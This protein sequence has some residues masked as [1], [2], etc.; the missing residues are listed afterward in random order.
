MVAGAG[1]AEELLSPL[2]AGLLESLALAL[3]LEL[4][5]A[6]E[7]LEALLLDE[8]EELSE[9]QAANIEATI[10]TESTAHKAFFLI[11]IFPPKNK[12]RIFLLR[13][14]VTPEN[15]FFPV[16]APILYNKLNKKTSTFCT[17]F[18]FFVIFLFQFTLNSQN[19]RAYL[20]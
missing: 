14:M 16:R 3:A 15:R 2:L 9:P 11:G 5:E 7:L 19:Q 13:Y 10:A 17:F 4:S 6:D 1:S 20:S 18:P 12:I 8:L